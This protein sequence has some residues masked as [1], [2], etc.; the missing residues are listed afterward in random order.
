MIKDI[1]IFLQESEKKRR[2]FLKTLS[3][4]RA[5]KILESLISSNILAALVSKPKEIPLSLE[6]SIKHAKLPR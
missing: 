1:K 2:N 5:V 6:K 3:L 4:G